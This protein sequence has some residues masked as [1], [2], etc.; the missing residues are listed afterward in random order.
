MAASYALAR[1]MDEAQRTM[2][3]LRRLDPALRLS[4]LK[5][6]LLF[7]RLEHLSVLSEGL[8]RAGLPE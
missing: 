6:W 3:D 8:R 2:G 4:G 7:Y 5:D 1:R